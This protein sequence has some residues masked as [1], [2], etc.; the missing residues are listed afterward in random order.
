MPPSEDYGIKDG[1]LYRA[2]VERSDGAQFLVNGATQKDWET[3]Q[4]MDGQTAIGQAILASIDAIAAVDPLVPPTGAAVG[5]NT[6]S[7]FA[8]ATI[9]LLTD[10]ANTE[11]VSPQT[12]SRARNWAE[13]VQRLA[14]VA[15]GLFR[16]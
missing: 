3:S 10:G 12:A 14:R 7:G 13:I 1:S 15:V 5:A 4:S 16:A 9:V 2:R 6:G 8:A 11:G